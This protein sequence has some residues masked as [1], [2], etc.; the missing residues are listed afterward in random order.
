MPLRLIP[1]AE[2]P[3]L[4]G[5]LAMGTTREVTWAGQEA[6]N[7]KWRLDWSGFMARAQ[8]GDK[9]AYRQLLQDVTP[10]VRSIAARHFQNPGD[11][12]DAVQD[13][14][15]TVHA[16]R[17]TYDPDRPFGPWLAAIANRRIVDCLRRQ[18]RSRSREIALEEDHVTISDPGA[19][20]EEASSDGQTLHEA[21]QKL[22]KG[23]R[24]AIQ[25]LK[26]QELSL[27]EAAAATG[28]SV[29]ALK[30]ATHR[31]LKNL[32]SMFG[33]EAK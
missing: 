29:A 24:E 5:K 22:P 7:P 32:K 10:Y 13:V 18:G 3:E 28:M 4:T 20:L 27:K 6:T 16:I 1:E 30:V 21:V 2:S 17:H 8:A 15:L 19:N 33:R 26:L 11:I 12:E 25:M 9:V 23:Q 14:F 31:G